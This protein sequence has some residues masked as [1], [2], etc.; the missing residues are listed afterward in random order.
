MANDTKQQVR[1][2]LKS[3]ETGDPGPIAAINP[4]KYTQHNLGAADGLAGFGALMA[5]LP[6]GSTKVNTV[7][8]FRDGDSVFAHSDYD[9][10]GP[11]IG[12]DIFRF[13]HGK[14]VE[15]WDNLQEKPSAPN[16]SG[17]T[18]TDGAVEVRDLDETEPNKKLVAGS[19]TGSAGCL[20][21]ATSYSP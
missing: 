20:A 11:K 7:R 17:H 1:D 8:V 10:F 5:Q 9:F 4:N 19:T 21:K 13:E 6:K 18:M 12:F 15:H 3:I 2:L 14:I 16:P